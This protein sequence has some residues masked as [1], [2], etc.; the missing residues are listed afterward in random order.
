M[1]MIIPVDSKINEA[2]HISEEHRKQADE[3]IPNLSHAESLVPHH[4]GDYDGDH[5]IAECFKATFSSILLCLH[6]T[7]AVYNYP[8][9]FH[10]TPELTGGESHSTLAS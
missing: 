4:N 9:V 7:I 6:A 8:I 3:G 1:V 10:L 5:S 2:Q